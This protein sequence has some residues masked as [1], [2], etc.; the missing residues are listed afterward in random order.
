MP[1]VVTRV[2]TINLH[3]SMVK[4]GN[5][6]SIG[7]KKRAPRAI[8]EIKKFAEKM[9]KTSDVRVDT[10]LNKFIWSKGVRNIPYRVRVKL[11]RRMNDDEEADEKLYTFAQLV[12]VPLGKFKGLQNETVAADAEE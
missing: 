10:E 9:M 11:S 7:F 12:P 5:R 1:D 8:R 2:C 4:A 3:K 6:K